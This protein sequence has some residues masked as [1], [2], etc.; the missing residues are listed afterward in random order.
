MRPILFL[1]LTAAEVRACAAGAAL[2]PGPAYASSATLRETFGYGPAEDE[3]ADFAAQVFAA[4]RALADGQPP[5]LLAM[6]VATL[7]AETGEREFGEI[8]RP[9]VRWRDVRALFLGDASCSEAYA[10][11]ARGRTLADLWADAATHDFLAVHDLLWFDAGELDHVLTELDR[12]PA[13]LGDS[14]KGD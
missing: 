5:C 7:P 6:E 13:E 4:L 12:V 14:P 10:E 11:T 8:E 2:G 1:P 3:D 9:P